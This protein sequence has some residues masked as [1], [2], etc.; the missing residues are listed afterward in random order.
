MRIY[1]INEPTDAPTDTSSE[2]TA[3]S[4]KP[5]KAVELLREE[6]KFSRRAIQ[7]LAIVKE[8]NI[9]ISLSDSYVSIH[10]RQSFVLQEKL[11][12]TKGASFFAVTS[13]V[14]NDAETGVPSL[15]SRL[16]VAVKRRIIWWTWRDTE[17]EPEVQEMA[18]P[19]SVKS[20][21]WVTASKMMVGMD[22]GFSLIDI[23]NKET[24]DIYKP[25]TAG[26]ATAAGQSGGV[27]F[28]A[29]SSSG[30]GYMGMGSWVPKPMST[31]L[32]H[33]HVL[34]AKDVNTLFV[35]AEGKSLEKRQIPWSFAP[36]AVGYSYPY[37]LS[38]Q[39]SN[40]AKGGALDIRNPHT[41]NLLQTISLPHAS[42]LHVPQPNISLAHAG[43]GFLVASDRRIW[44][45]AALSYERQI[46][47]LVAKQKL[48]E[49]ISLLEM[50]EDTLLSDK[51]GRLREIRM[52]KAQNLFELQKYRPAL[53]LFTDAQAP[54]ARV[55]ALY[56]KS[57]AG[58]LSRI[59]ES[60]EGDQ[61]A[62]E[63]NTTITED[64]TIKTDKDDDTGSKDQSH[65]SLDIKDFPRTSTDG[66]AD[67]TGSLQ[68]SM[69][70]RLTGSMRKADSDTAS[71]RS[72]ST[73]A[74][75]SSKPAA[76]PLEGPDLK[77]AVLALC[78]FL[79]QSRV[80]IQKFLSTDG[81]LKVPIDEKDAAEKP[82][83]K[84][85]IDLPA[86]ITTPDW[87]TELL[88]V[89]KLV[90]TTLF[91]AYMH[92][93]P[94]LAGPLFRLDN[95]CDP[96]V[97][98]DK[99]YEHG[100]YQDLIDFLYGKKLHREALEEL[101]R[102]G[103]NEAADEVMPALR[104]PGRTVAYLQQL[105]PEMMDIILEFAEWPIR[106]EPEVG[107]QVFTADTEN[108]E[109]LPRE[110]V[111]EFL[112]GV[113]KGLA[114]QYLEH[115]INEL[116]DTSPEFH[117]LLVDFYLE[118]LKSDNFI[119]ESDKKPAREKLEEFLTTSTR[120]NKVKTFNQLP[121]DGRFCSGASTFVSNTLT[122]D[123]QIPT[124]S[125]LEPLSCLP[126]ATINKPCR[127]MSSIYALRRRQKRTVTKST[128]LLPRLAPRAQHLH[129]FLLYSLHRPTCPLPTVAVLHS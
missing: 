67:I 40:G 72:F 89:A 39:Q 61:S 38:L 87:Q 13:N 45:M 24:T 115:V 5:P 88:D 52:L 123:H 81:T 127:S 2:S 31:N 110:Q 112:T 122:I 92:A 79:A 91:R 118:R 102:F 34:L 90:D 108:A 129:T 17:L 12:K 71:I 111:L 10:N 22:P 41:L 51:E 58:E 26:E 116:G 65:A 83:F 15:V 46:D 21:I 20:L 37:L 35:D 121:P 77:A 14:V 99:L 57:I 74:E 113:D 128:S 114:I 96:R 103:K 7:Q 49:A 75:T 82:P 106:T 95:F 30:M 62:D 8:A 97:V 69:L 28:G 100:R 56:P 73:T 19:H 64:D 104:G 47:Q 119:T 50:L 101:A 16:A 53:D 36:E 66:N 23:D 54:P 120:Y 68:R 105:P 107:M 3:P 25:S 84:Y 98:E 124:S 93:L 6:E 29:V 48:D 55:I 94:S 32:R 27:R 117:Q 59:D 60:T 76:K 1:R 86:E 80:Q 11:E 43:K 125:S 109:N 78:S 4:T 63:T 70:G 33:G 42:I 85:L 18:L 44:R 9:L 126:W